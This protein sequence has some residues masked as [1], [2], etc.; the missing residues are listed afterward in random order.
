MAW[1]TVLPITGI[2]TRVGLMQ[3]VG[4]IDW[5]GERVA[6]IGAPLFAALLICLIGAAASAFASTTGIL[7]A[8]IPLAVPFLLG[9][10]IGA[11][12]LIIALA[13]SSSIVEPSPF[14]TSGTL[15]VANSP[16]DL[17]DKVYKNLLRWGMSMI[18]VIPLITWLVFVLPGQYMF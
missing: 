8:L 14:S 5:L 17:R 13:L 4:T 1:P 11:V 10:E 9:G 3:E 2:V 7:A 12:S 15:C 16:D 18:V 6:D